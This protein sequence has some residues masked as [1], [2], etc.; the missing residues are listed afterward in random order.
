MN[1][2]QKGI[3]PEKAFGYLP[4][5][6]GENVHGGVPKTTAQELSEQGQYRG[7]PMP[8]PALIPKGKVQLVPVPWLLAHVTEQKLSDKRLEDNESLMAW[9]NEGNKLPPI[10]I[11]ITEE[12]VVTLLDGHHRLV[13]AVNLGWDTIEAVVDGIM[14]VSPTCVATTKKGN[15]CKA[16]AQKDSAKCVGHNR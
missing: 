1:T 8:G 16:Y 14:P 4:L 11:A 6:E 10:H 13:V 15:P 5:G 12:G 3:S 7:I 2:F 9:M